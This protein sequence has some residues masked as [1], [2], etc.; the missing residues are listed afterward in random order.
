MTNQNKWQCSQCET[1]VCTRTSEVKPDQCTSNQRG[2]SDPSQWALVLESKTHGNIKFHEAVLQMKP[3]DIFKPDNR[4]Y[5]GFL[6]TAD[7]KIVSSDEDRTE[8]K[9]FAEFFNLTGKI[10]RAEPRVKSMEE[11]IKEYH[12]SGPLDYSD[13]FHDGKEQGRLERDLEYREL[14]KRVREDLNSYL[15]SFPRVTEALK[16]LKPLSKE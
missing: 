2:L 7:G 4:D 5:Q 14:V 15:G 6:L 12:S 13:G 3:G 16:N 11:C 10:I 8:L 1:T 9:L